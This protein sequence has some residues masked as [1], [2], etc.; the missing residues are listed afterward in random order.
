MTVPWAN[1]DVIGSSDIFEA[2]HTRLTVQLIMTTRDQLM[3]CR[4]DDDVA[5]IMSRNTARY[6]FIPVLDAAHKGDR[7][8]GLFHAARF[9]D[10]PV[11]NG[12]VR[13]HLLPLAEEHLI[14]A[15]ASIL[16]FL[17]S[18][19][20][21]PCRLVL[22]GAGISG[23]VSLSDLHRLPVRACLF[24]LITGLEITMAEAIRQRY[25]SDEDWLPFLKEER[26]VKIQEEIAS[27]KGNDF[28]VD[29]LLFTQFADKKTII[30]MGIDAG[31]SKST[32][33]SQLGRIEQL[34]NNVAHANDYAPS[35]DEARKV[36]VTVRK[37][38]VLQEKIAK[39]AA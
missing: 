20:S 3:M 32:L 35:P 38:L 16:D 12:S 8:K 26:R 23:L 27:S 14:G 17:T 33:E 28:F 13:D 2:M 25:P 18:A 29:P 21:N 9:F 36:C 19:D 5:G 7:I 10:G 39:V 15:D 1:Y 30:K 4:A 31:L 34:R 37:L 11:P 22:S 24:A 6:D